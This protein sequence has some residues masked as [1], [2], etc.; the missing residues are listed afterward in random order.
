MTPDATSPTFRRV[1]EGAPRRRRYLSC[2]RTSSGRTRR[3]RTVA[4]AILLASSLRAAAAGDAVT[5]EAA[6]RGDAVAVAARATLHAPLPLIW[7][8]LTDYDHLAEFIPGMKQSRVIGRRGSAAIVEQSGEAGFLVFKYPIDVIVESDEH[9]PTTIAIRVLAGNLKRLEGGYR[10]EK[11]PGD[12]DEFVLSWEGVI[13]P[14]ISLPM[15][16]SVPLLRANVAEQ[17]VG[18]VKEI[19]HREKLRRA[20]PG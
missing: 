6:R 14:D 12:E 9:A 7:Q 3:G 8:T 17:F 1:C 20:G 2:R 19:E 16:I 18:M 5:V 11:S 4:I 15:F 13:E 10:L